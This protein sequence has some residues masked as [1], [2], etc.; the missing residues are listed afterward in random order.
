MACLPGGLVLLGEAVGG[1]PLGSAVLYALV[2]TPLL[3]ARGRWPLPAFLGVLAVTVVAGPMTTLAVMI[4][5][6]A[7]GLSCSRVVTFGA[8][9][10]ATVL[11]TAVSGLDGA[12]ELSEW[13]LS[14]FAL[15]AIGAGAGIW[16]DNR[17]AYVERLRDHAARL[18]RERELL[19]AQAVAEERLRIARE[20]HDAVGHSVSL[21]VVQAQALAVG[22]PPQEREKLLALADGGRA[23]MTELHR[24][25]GVLRVDEPGEGAERLPQPGV[26]DL[27]ALIA[28][29]RAGGVDA[30]LGIE[31]IRRPLPATVEVSAYRIVQEALTNV[32]RHVG[33]ARAE[34]TVRFAPS[35]LELRVEDDGGPVPSPAP[36]APA[37]AGGHGLAGMR[38]RVALFGGSLEARRRHDGG[39]FVVHAI[40]PL[41]GES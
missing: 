10:A 30:R 23:A 38:E 40:L 2:V 36:A 15:V 32:V 18:E 9:A 33:T 21:L 6:Y 24:M 19:A 3:L 37:A 39:G 27:G 35:R 25:L 13:V 1:R 34:V 7:V 5:A 14:H 41:G 12:R 20:L 28:G 31:G 11:L 16:Q 26:D 29:A 17:A 8:V 22:A 4:A